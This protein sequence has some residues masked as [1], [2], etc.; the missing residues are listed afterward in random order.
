MGGGG[1]RVGDGRK[2]RGKER[3]GRYGRK[4]PLPPSPPP[5]TPRNKSLLR[6]CSCCC[7]R[8]ADRVPVFI[9][10]NVRR[11]AGQFVRSVDEASSWQTAIVRCKAEGH[12]WGAAAAVYRWYG[13]TRRWCMYA[14]L[15]S[16]EPPRRPTKHRFP[17]PPPATVHRQTDRQTYG[18]EQTDTEWYI[19]LTAVWAC[20][21][22]LLTDRTTPLACVCVCGGVHAERELE[23]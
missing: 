8:N 23:R 7:L 1:K 14:E 5:L 20:P 2:E 21:V 17:P 16:R 9:C 13:R 18:A 3:D 22:L 4:T 6:P 19:L 10:G 12:R 15:S 11:Y